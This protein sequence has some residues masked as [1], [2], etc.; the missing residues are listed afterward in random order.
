MKMEYEYLKLKIV[1]V[2][3]LVIPHL[4]KFLSLNAQLL[5]MLC[6]C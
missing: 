3:L 2:I 1:L 6:N 5:I 4:A